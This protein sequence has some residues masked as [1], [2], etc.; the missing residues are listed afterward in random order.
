MAKSGEQKTQKFLRFDF[1]VMN[2]YRRGERI[3]TSNTECYS[4]LQNRH[5]VHTNLLLT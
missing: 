4:A 1:C 3:R 2:V 5:P